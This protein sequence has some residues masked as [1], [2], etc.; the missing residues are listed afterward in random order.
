M[1]E[2]LG[3]PVRDCLFSPLND[4]DPEQALLN[5]PEKIGVTAYLHVCLYHS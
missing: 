3:R 1:D 2:G 4:E 5:L